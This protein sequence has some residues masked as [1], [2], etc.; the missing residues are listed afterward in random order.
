MVVSL[1][2]DLEW[3]QSPNSTKKWKWDLQKLNSN[4]ELREE[5]E[6]EVK[7]PLTKWEGRW[8]HLNSGA[9]GQP[10]LDLAVDELKSI[11]IEAADKVF[12]RKQSRIRAA[13]KPWWSK[14][15]TAAEKARR[16]QF[17]SWK[18]EG[19]VPDSVAKARLDK[20]K[21]AYKALIRKEKRSFFSASLREAGKRGSPGRARELHRIFRRVARK[22]AAPAEF[23]GHRATVD[24]VG[25]KIRCTNAK[26]VR[27]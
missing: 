4:P 3:K 25:P 6:Q 21:K 7:A 23:L 24:Y 26:H 18:R 27:C 19:K 22:R 12:G 13:A 14:E 8:R 20:A 9:V 5:F 15:L 2:V 11:L 16:S 10:Q 17:Q 1:G